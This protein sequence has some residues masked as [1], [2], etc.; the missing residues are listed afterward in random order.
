MAA[1]QAYAERDPTT[2]A[3][4]E[5]GGVRTFV[6]VPMLRENELIGGLTLC[7]QEVRPFTDKQI[8]L[9][10][11]FA[12]QAVIA[13]ENARLLNELR[14][15]TQDLGEAL[16]Q[17]TG[18]LEVLQVISRSQDELKL[19]FDT[20]L[21]NAT[22]LCAANSGVLV[23]YESGTFRNVAMFN[24]PM[25][26]AKARQRDPVIPAGPLSA[27]GRVAATKKLVHIP[28]YFEDAAY[29]EGDPAAISL[30]ERAG[31]RSLVVVPMLRDDELIGAIDIFRQ[32]VRP[33]TE[34]QIALLQNFA[35]Q[36]VIA[37][38]NARLLNELRQSLEQQ[39]A[40]A[41]VLKVISSSPGEL[42]AA[43]Q[44]LLTNAARL[45]EADLGTISL[46]EDGTFRAAAA[47]YNVP[48]AYSECRQREPII[49]P[50]PRSPLARVTATKQL[51]HI[52]DCV[53]DV[54]YRERDASA[55]VLSTMETTRHSTAPRASS[56]IRSLLVTRALFFAC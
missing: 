45:C 19:V 41:D 23:L 38:E 10:K 43:F 56:T 34:K 30:V 46:Y 11:N 22:R 42:D 20:I 33:F 8:E 36:A 48:S 55:V 37:I 2:V 26:F 32:E 1:E 6:V 47:T 53:E 40:T 29:R 52:Y 5:L 28:N 51:L 21:V 49:R 9:V 44:T 7:R 18:T 12:A 35:A 15:R 31:A 54:G 25:E 13:I 27:L 24:P 39:T 16:E 3:A 14:R 17:Q 50:G 4:V